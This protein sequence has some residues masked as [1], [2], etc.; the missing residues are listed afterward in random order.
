MLITICTGTNLMAAESTYTVKAGDTLCEISSKVG[1][2]ADDLMKLNNLNSDFLQIGTQLLIQLPSQNASDPASLPT[3]NNSTVYYVQSGDNLWTIAR[4]YGMTVARLMQNNNLTSDSLSIGQCLKVE[5][6]Q[7]AP[8]PSRSGNLI[9]GLRI[10]EKAQE[11]LGTAYRYGG[12]SPGGFDCSGFVRYIFA[13]FGFNLPHNAAAQFNNGTGVEK[14]A[15]EAGDLV[16]FACS[17]S[18]IDHV[19]IYSGD[20]QFIHSSSPRSGGVIYSSLV[21]GYYA[22]RYAGAKRILR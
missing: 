13:Q 11:Y 5:T 17:G 3:V 9:D 2:S 7:P 14:S 8:T 16:F 10:I 4:K 19:G 21:N 15:L 12:T 6:A 22:G 18:G 20:N 1:T